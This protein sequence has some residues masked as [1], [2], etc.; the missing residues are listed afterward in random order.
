MRPQG[1]R[2]H[3]QLQPGGD[4]P[5][6]PG[7]FW[8]H[9]SRSHQAGPAPATFPTHRGLSR[10]SADTGPPLPTA[11]KPSFN[12]HLFTAPQTGA[13]PS[14]Q[15]RPLLPTLPHTCQ[16]L[17]PGSRG[18]PQSCPPGP[19]SWPRPSPLTGKHPAPWS[20][21]IRL[22]AARCCRARDPPASFTSAFP[23][24]SLQGTAGAW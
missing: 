14:E 3:G 2:D 22:P 23:A 24:P 4:Q 6:R 18:L 9:R 12:P 10:Y 16:V 8:S 1:R 13:P 17:A 20:R 11:L 21:P 5:S 7:S 15:G 19:C